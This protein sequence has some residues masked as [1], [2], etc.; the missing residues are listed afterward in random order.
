MSMIFATF[1]YIVITFSFIQNWLFL[2]VAAIFL[3]SIK[4]NSVAL[5]PLAILIDGYFG[6][7]FNIPMLS[8]AA[9]L[10]FMVVEFLRHKFIHFQTN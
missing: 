1:L 10:W 9:I 4:Y 8:I 7:F 6:N 5:I 2:A 3:F